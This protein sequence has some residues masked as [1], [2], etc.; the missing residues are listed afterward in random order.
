MISDYSF[1]FNLTNNLRLDTVKELAYDTDFVTT[2]GPVNQ[3]GKNDQ[4]W[5]DI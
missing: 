3:D 2:V 4:S 1:L 5:E